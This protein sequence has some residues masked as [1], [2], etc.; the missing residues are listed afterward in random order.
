[1]TNEFKVV[2]EFISNHQQ[3]NIQYVVDELQN[4]ISRATI[5]NILKELVTN[6]AVKDSRD[7]ENSRDHKLSV[8]TNNLLVSVPKELETLQKYFFHCLIRQRYIWIP[9]Q[10]I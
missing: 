10:S 5:F 2:I 7:H 3:C 6:G 1:M 9:I 4:K 8:E